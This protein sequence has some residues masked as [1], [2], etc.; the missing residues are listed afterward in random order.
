MYVQPL[1]ALEMS[2]PMLIYEKDFNEV[3]LQLLLLP[4]FLLFHSVTPELKAEDI[5]TVSGRLHYPSVLAR[6][7][8]LASSMFTANFLFCVRENTRKEQ[9]CCIPSY[10]AKHK[11]V[12]Q[13]N[14][15]YLQ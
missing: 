5:I 2:L 7:V 6:P 4:F 12:Q 14:K 15:D 1:I 11:Q 13:Q 8:P 10:N 3:I 9:P